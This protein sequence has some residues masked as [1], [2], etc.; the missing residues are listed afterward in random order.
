MKCPALPTKV[1]NLFTS[2]YIHIIH[3][4]KQLQYN[5]IRYLFYERLCFNLVLFT[6]HLFLY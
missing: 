1:K 2:P 5:N 6:L 3:I 4:M